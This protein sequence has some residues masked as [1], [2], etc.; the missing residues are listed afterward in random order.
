MYSDKRDA[1]IDVDKLD[2][3]M[4]EKYC[5]HNSEYIYYYKNA[6]GNWVHGTHMQMSQYADGSW[7]LSGSPG[8]VVYREYTYCTQKTPS[9]LYYFYSYSEWSEW[10]ETPMTESDTIEVETKEVS[11]DD[12]GS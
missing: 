11:Y 7:I 1:G 4:N 8:M 9:Y 12:I 2:E 5:I 3:E 6:F 10:S